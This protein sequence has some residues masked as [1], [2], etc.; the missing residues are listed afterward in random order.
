MDL[1]SDIVN[2][3]N[4][5]FLA[6]HKIYSTFWLLSNSPASSTTESVC[7]ESREVKRRFE[8]FVQG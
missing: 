5:R 6:V 3:R 7:T 1:Q 8:K 2:P 4:A